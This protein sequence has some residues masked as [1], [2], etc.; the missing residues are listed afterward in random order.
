LKKER[1]E[2]GAGETG[3]CR[4]LLLSGDLRQHCGVEELIPSIGA[5]R[6]QEEVS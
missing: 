2:E 1:E 5:I 3:D 4:L 6:L